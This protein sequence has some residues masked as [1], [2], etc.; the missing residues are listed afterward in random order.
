MV[1]RVDRDIG[2]QLDVIDA[3]LL[4]ETTHHM[5]RLD[6]PTVSRR[7]EKGDTA[8]AKRVDHDVAKFAN[9]S[10]VGRNWDE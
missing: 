5:T 9:E 3:R 2:G 10:G 7:E 4:K 1:F 8:A 6:L